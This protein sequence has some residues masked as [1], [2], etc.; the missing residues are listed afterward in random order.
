M[1]RLNLPEYAASQHG[2]EIEWRNEDHS[3]AM[4]TKEGDVLRATKARDGTWSYDS[5]SATDRGDII[6]FELHRGAKSAAEA[7]D[8]VRPVLERVEREFGRLDPQ[9]GRTRGS[10]RGF[11]RDDGPGFER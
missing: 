5:G 8:A 11:D 2:Y 1:H 3:R 10:V 7:R 9:R 6:D 4:L